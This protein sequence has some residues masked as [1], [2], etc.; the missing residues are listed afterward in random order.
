MGRIMVVKDA[1]APPAWS[2]RFHASLSIHEGILQNPCPWRFGLI[3]PQWP[4]L[5]FGH[6]P[7]ERGKPDSFQGSLHKGEGS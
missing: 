5:S 7:R 1:W 2:L 6:F 3:I 4:P